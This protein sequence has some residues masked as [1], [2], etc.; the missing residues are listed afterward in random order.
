MKFKAD[1]SQERIGDLEKSLAALPGTIP[2]IR[3]YEFGRDVLHSQRSYDFSLVS[4][5][6]DMDAMKRYQAHPAHQAVIKIVQEVC[7][8]VLAVDFNY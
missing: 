8:N 2:E 7:E 5:F 3:S 1:V 6:D 4:G